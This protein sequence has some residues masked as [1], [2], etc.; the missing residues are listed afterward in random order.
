MP[1]FDADI[2]IEDFLED[3]EPELS[4]P[5]YRF[6]E[7]VT[8]LVRMHNNISKKEAEEIVATVIRTKEN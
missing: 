7:R 5:K 1:E 3:D 2:N 6:K 8:R 4:D